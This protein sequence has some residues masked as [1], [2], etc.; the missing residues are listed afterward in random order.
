MPYAGR[1]LTWP[2]P[3]NTEMILMKCQALPV[4]VILAVLSA[5]ALAD[6]VRLKSGKVIKDLNLIKKPR[7]P[8]TRRPH[9]AQER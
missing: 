6:D 4:L 9:R 8:N 2:A 3:E 1:D 5:S 7:R